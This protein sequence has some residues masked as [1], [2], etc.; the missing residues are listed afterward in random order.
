MPCPSGW[1]EVTGLSPDAPDTT[2]GQEAGGILTVDLAALVANWRLA[3]ATAG[4]AACAAVMKAD[5]YGTGIAA[6]GPALAAAGCETFFVA[7]LSEARRLRAAVPGATIYVLN[8]LLP[9]TE[10]VYP[11]LGLR[12]VLGSRDEINAWMAFQA[13]QGTDLPVALHVDTGMNRL[14]LEIAEALDLAAASSGFRPAL[15]MSHLACADEPD[16]PLTAQQLDR[17]AAL[18]AAFPGVPGSIANSSGLFGVPASRHDLVRP[19]YALYGGN[20]TPRRENP[21]RPVVTLEARIIQVGTAEDGEGVG[22][23]AGWTARGRRLLAVASVGYADGYPRALSGRDGRPGGAA[24]VHGVRCPLA[25]RVSM[26]LVTIDVTD[27]PL[28]VQRGDFARLVDETLTVDV[29]GAAAGSIGY[30]VLTGLGRRYHRRY[31]GA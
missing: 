19:G 13:A 15:L 1:N 22:Y 20:P 25:G 29:V 30:E 4:T 3:A 8:G 18:R 27:V 23:S 17:F 11:A 6:A 10:A 31:V 7:H 16:H 14:G 5:A 2:D 24:M 26:D 12:P 9:S 21:M 28:P